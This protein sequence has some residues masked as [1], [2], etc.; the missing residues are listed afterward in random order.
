MHPMILVGQAPPRAGLPRGPLSGRAALDHLSALASLDPDDLLAS[1]ERYNLLG[2]FPGRHPSGKGDALPPAS[3][4]RAAA[5]LVPKLRGRRALLLGRGV[6]RAFGVGDLPFFVWTPCARRG[7]RLLP[8]VEHGS[9]AALIAV[10]P[11][12]SRVSRWWN[13]PANRAAAAA[14]LSGALRG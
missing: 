7:G 4:R 11:H 12:P 10:V 2:R 1:T 6:A 3:A 14:F 5:R 9:G 8:L 13:M